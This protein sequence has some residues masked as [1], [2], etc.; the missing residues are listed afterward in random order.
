[1]SFYPTKTPET[2]FVMLFH[3]KNLGT[4]GKESTFVPSHPIVLPLLDEFRTLNWAQIKRDIEFSK[5]FEMLPIKIVW[6]L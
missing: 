4:K 3:L 5:I 1:M 2:H 6:N